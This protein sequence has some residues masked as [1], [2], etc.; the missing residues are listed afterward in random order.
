MVREREEDAGQ[1][2]AENWPKKPTLF[3]GK[4]IPTCC[5]QPLGRF[6]WSVDSDVHPEEQ[7]RLSAASALKDRTAGLMR[8]L[9]QSWQQEF[10]AAQL[11]LFWKRQK[12]FSSMYT[13]RKETLE[14]LAVNLIWTFSSPPFLSLGPL[15]LSSHS[16]F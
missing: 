2:K 9:Q 7:A 11:N 13:K 15:S 8:L 4:L 6:L 16:L 3:D 1:P 10:D 12:L 14:N 5:W